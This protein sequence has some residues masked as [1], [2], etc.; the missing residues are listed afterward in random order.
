MT[1]VNKNVPGRLKR[2]VMVFAGGAPQYRAL[3]E[4]EVANGY[5]GFALS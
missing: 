3:C 4:A 1:G 5:P 2:N